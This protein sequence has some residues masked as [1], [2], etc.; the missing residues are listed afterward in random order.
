MSRRVRVKAI[1]REKPD[2]RLYV[3]ALLALAREMRE[4]EP[5][6]PQSSETVRRESTSEADHD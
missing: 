1:M 3:E 2:I 6:M 5:Q 4:A